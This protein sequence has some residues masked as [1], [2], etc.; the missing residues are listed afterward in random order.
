MFSSTSFIDLVLK[1]LSFRAN[2]CI[3]C[4]VG[5]QIHSFACGYPDISVLFAEITILYSSN[6]LAPCQRSFDHKCKDISMDSLFYS[7]DLCVYPVPY[8]LGYYTL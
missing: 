7:I 3:W 2:F 6:V 1:C 8:C 4:E 5:T